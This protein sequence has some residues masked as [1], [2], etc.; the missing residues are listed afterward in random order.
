MRDWIIER[1]LKPS[2]GLIVGATAALVIGLAVGMMLAPPA[3]TLVAAYLLLLPV[4]LIAY[5]FGPRW[6]WG[7]AAVAIL[8]LGISLLADPPSRLGRSGLVEG[9]LIGLSYFVVGQLVARWAEKVTTAPTPD[10]ALIVGD[11]QLQDTLDAIL[12]SM[13]EIISYDVAE[14]TLWD[15]QRHRCVTQGWVGDQDY[16]EA[17]GGTYGVD[18]GFTG[19]LI[20]RQRP[21]FISDGASHYDARPKVDTP[22][23]PFQSYIGIPLQLHGRFI[24]TLELASY[25]ENAYTKRDFD[26]LQAVGGQAAIAVENARLRAQSDEE[27][28]RRVDALSSVQRVSREINATLNLDRILHLVLQETVSLGRAAYAAIALRDI[29]SEDGDLELR[30]YLGYREAGEKSL[31]AALHAPEEHPIL[32]EVLQIE[33][34]FLVPDLSRYASEDGEQVEFAP[35]A[36]SMLVVPIFYAERLTGLIL[37]EDV[38]A[39]TFDQ[40]TLEFVEGLSAQTS[41]AIGNARRY[42][43]QMERGN[44]LRHRAEQLASVLEISRA[45]RSDRPL[46]EILEEIAY[47]IQE[48]VGFDLVVASVKEGDPPQRRPMAA[49]GIP[50]FELERMK[51]D[52]QPWA[53]VE[54]AMDDRF[55]ISQSYYIPVEEELDQRDQ[56]VIRRGIQDE[57]LADRPRQP[58]HWHPCDVLLV[59]LIGPGGDVEGVLSVGSPRDGRVPDRATVETVEIFASQAALAIENVHMVE[60]LQRRAEVLALF[61]EISQSATAKLELS[62]VLGEVVETAPQLLS[63]DHSGIFL[64]DSDGERYVLRAVQGVDFETMANLAWA[65]DGGLVDQVADSGMPLSIDDL[66]KEPKF[67]SDAQSGM[68][69]LLLTPLKV[70]NQVVGILT[71]GRQEPDA[72]LPAEVAMLSALADQMA[73]AVENARL[74]QDAQSRAVRLE[75]AA[76]V[77]RDAVA[78]LDVDQLLDESVQ[79]I[80]DKFGFYHASVFLL[81]KEGDY[82]SLQAAS[83]EGGQRM[84]DEGHTLAVGETS[85]VGYVAETGDP[86]L[87]LDVGKD[88]VHFA[89]PHLPNTRSEM[90]LPLISRGEIIGVLDVQSV[91]EMAFT[92]EDLATLQIM[93]DQLANAI[94]NARLYEEIRQRTAQ[95]EALREV[96]LD[97]TAE[98]SLDETLHSIVTRSVDLVDA[99]AGGFNLYVPG[100]DVLD[101]SI[102]AGIEET[103]DETFIERGEGIAGKVWETGEAILINDYR[104]WVGHSDRWGDYLGHIADMAVP[105]QWGDEFLG[106]LEVMADPPRTFSQE[107]AD[108]LK[109]FATQAAI[110]IA[111]ARLYEETVSRAKRLTVVNRIARAAGATLDLDELL[112]TVYQ[113]TESV[114]EADAFFIA[115]YDEEADELD[116][117]IQVDEGKR[118]PPTREPLGDTLTGFVVT[119]KEPLLIR[120]YE[121]QGG[122]PS[123]ETWGTEKISASWLGAPMRSGDDV[124]GVISVQ[125]YRPDVY[126]DEEELLLST[127]A[128]Q[129]A[130]AVENARLFEEVRSFSHVLEQRVEE[131]TRELAA[132]MDELTE[133]RDRMEALYRITSQLAASLDLDHVLSKALSLVLDACR[134]DRA[135]ALLLDS[136][137]GQLIQRSVQGADVD[138]PPGGKPTRFSRG[139]GLAGW[140]VEHRETA[141]VSNIQQDERWVEPQNKEREYS[142]AMGVPLIVSGEVLGALLLLHSETDY[143]DEDHRRLVETAAGQIS[144]AINNANLYEVIRE[145]AESLG[146]MLKAQQVEAAKSEAILEGVADGVMVADADGRVTLFNAAAERILQLPREE[147]LGRTTRERLGLYG[148]QARDWMETVAR[149]AEDPQS[150][151]PGDYLAAQLTI[152]DRIVSVHLAPVLMRNEFLGTVSVFRD[153]TAEVEA[154]R[155]KTD[156]V[157]MVSHELRTPMTSIKGYADLILMEAAGELTDDQRRFMGTIK[158]NVDR[159]VTLVNEL[160]DISRIESGRLELEPEPTRVIKVVDSVLTAMKARAESEDLTLKKDLPAALPIVNADPDRLEQILTNLV[161]NAVQYTPPGGEITVSAQAKRDEVSISVADTGIGISPEAQDKIFDRFFRADDSRVQNTSGTGLGLSIVQSLVELHGGEIWVESEVDEGTIF[162]FTLP[163]E[164]SKE[165]G[166]SLTRILVVE[167]DPDIAYL[168]KLHL[169]GE[170]RDVMIAYHGEEALSIARRERPD[171]ITLDIMLPDRSGFEVLEELKSDPA[172]KEI[173]VVIVSVVED[174]EEGLQLGAADYLTKPVDEERL[175]KVVSQVLTRRRGT[176]LVVDDDQDTLSLLRDVLRTSD[177]NVKTVKRGQKALSVARNLS[178]SLVLL[179]LKLMDVEGYTVLKQLKSDAKTRDIPVIVMTGSEVINDARRQKVLALG[180]DRFIAKPFSIENLIGEIETVIWDDGHGESGSEG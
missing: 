101:F 36:R 105:V 69:S 98:L 60:E 162:T 147:A 50:V 29:E 72:F 103:P 82:A 81:N 158:N 8:L 92:E 66:K 107:D 177:F 23:Y 94:R 2:D 116:Y 125:A 11:V 145:Q 38:E 161:G 159:L 20:R 95:L 142:S 22:D 149:W 59:P 123:A 150:Y 52:L 174:R 71:V 67:S 18:E 156:F 87:A 170:K 144:Q 96:A 68:R 137:T 35:D 130:V 70:G 19:W 132:A 45:L 25:E 63:C 41:T 106:V 146:E 48:T 160:L 88:A 13:G 49:A 30:D 56:L 165:T 155:A 93:A 51:D 47:A 75:V 89:N 3:W 34:S 1:Q 166:E 43:E 136:N 40:H 173:P 120:N 118:I 164:E 9:L 139:E 180:A 90:A 102:H 77:A 44:Q 104:E 141:I 21:L 76:E 78:I 129:V 57:D 178:P 133:E 127:I 171:L 148:D 7:A 37:L 172:T 4:G 54:Q 85:I 6:A 154:D 84:L 109:L 73:V 24:G 27:L 31:R 143:F 26:I 135:S 112:E 111:N 42:R 152:E 64:W 140:V 134:V 114:F 33:H 17:T 122:F 108:L 15:E 53:L 99:N 115:L 128:D 167:D 46:E 138:L 5:R 58:G 119:E 79:L 28:H 14:I 176:V 163:T 39:S 175:M 86:R 124:V 55:F 131:R 83:S 61:N 97:I 32:A 12:S 179:D 80:S 10:G 153:V 169:S 126:G 121:E 113:E 168:I 62:E 117:R 151:E 91:Q 157:S 110:A 100:R 16:V 65:S 74:F